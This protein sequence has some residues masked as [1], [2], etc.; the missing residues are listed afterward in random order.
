MTESQK[1]AENDRKTG[2]VTPKQRKAIAALLSSRTIQD[3]AKAAK[4]SE[5]TLYRWMNNPDFR[6]ALA[7][8]ESDAID[9]ATRRLIDLQDA[10]ID[11]LKSLLTNKKA[12]PWVKL[13]AAQMVLNSVPKRREQNKVESELEE[14][15]VLVNGEQ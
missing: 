10:A 5:R 4:V 2:G 13:Q 6:A 9:Q 12:S 11:A 8:A 1:M 14:L 15:E 3:A 7:D